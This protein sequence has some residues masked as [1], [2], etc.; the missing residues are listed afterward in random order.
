M[1]NRLRSFREAGC[2]GI[3]AVMNNGEAL[4]LTRSFRPCSSMTCV[5]VVALLASVAVVGRIVWGKF[6]K[7]IAGILAVGGVLIVAASVPRYANATMEP[8]LFGTEIANFTLFTIDLTT[9][10]A[11]EFVGPMAAN[12]DYAGFGID[13]FGQFQV[14]AV[15]DAIVFSPAD[16]FERIEQTIDNAEINVFIDNEESLV[17]RED[18]FQKIG[19][20]TAQT[21]F[22]TRNQ[23]V[24]DGQVIGSVI[25]QAED[26]LGAL[27]TYGQFA[28]IMESDVD[29]AE[30]GSWQ[31]GAQ[32]NGAFR[33]FM[34]MNAVVVGGVSQS[35]ELANTLALASDTPIRDLQWNTDDQA[36]V[37]DTFGKISIV[38]EDRAGAGT[39]DGSMKL[40]VMQGVQVRGRRRSIRVGLGIGGYFD[41]ERVAAVAANQLHQ[42]G[43]VAD[44]P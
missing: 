32:L 8:V 3:F 20:G 4:I 7:L 26:G 25:F 13:N 41:V 39:E 1:G 35:V 34:R 28:S 23:T 27:A 9:G 16:L 22:M 44:I 40:F 18:D 14:N 31:I 38:M 17:I 29:T 2:D 6:W 15:G 30:Q 12:H 37:M 42:F 24:T 5:F 19:V 43:G 33:V 11:G 36:G 21:L 10:A